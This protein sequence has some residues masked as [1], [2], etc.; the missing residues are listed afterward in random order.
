MSKALFWTAASACALIASALSMS[1]PTVQ[2]SLNNAAPPGAMGTLNGIAYSASIGTKAIFP[3]LCSGLYAWGLDHKIL[4]GQL[5]WA[6]LLIMAIGYAALVE[7]YPRE[8]DEGKKVAE[9][10]EEQES[11]SSD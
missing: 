6:V 2:M 3:A 8:T 11:P 1:Y 7:I 5:A 10:D 9:V 4:K